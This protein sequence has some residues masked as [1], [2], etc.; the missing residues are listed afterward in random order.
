MGK[1]RGCIMGKVELSDIFRGEYLE[2][3]T[4]HISR[5]QEILDEYDVAIFMARKAICFYEALKD[6]GE[7]TNSNC[8]VVSGRIVYYNTL[9]SY[10]NKRIAVIDDVVVRGNSINRVAT[11]L[12]DYGIIADYYVAAC[13]LRFQTEFENTYSLSIEAHTTYSLNEIYH[14]SGLITQYI[15]A[16]M[17]TF[18]V[19]SPIYDVTNPSEDVNSILDDSGAVHLTSGLQEKF[20]IES[21]SIY[22]MYACTPESKTKIDEVLCNSI[23]KIRFYNNDERTIA[24]PFVLLPACDRDTLED[25][26]Q[27][28]ES[29]ELDD[30]IS[31]I[32]PRRTEE[33]KYK[34]ISYFL[35]D[36]LFYCFAKRFSLDYKRDYLND[37]LQFDKNLDD[38]NSD[39][40]NKVLRNLMLQTVNYKSSFS[41]YIFTDYISSAYQFV[42][43]RDLGEQTYE[44]A[45]GNVFGATL[46]EPEGKLGAIAFSFTD[47]YEWIDKRN[48]DNIDSFLYASSVIDVFVDMGLIVPAILHTPDN[49]ILRAYKMGEYSKLTRDQVNAFLN[50]LKTYQKIVDRDLRKIEL[51]K[52]CV[53][54]FKSLIKSGTFAEKVRFED[55]VYSI[56]YSFY[57]PRLSTS[58]ERYTV[59]KDSAFITDFVDN[60]AIQEINGRY[61]V[62]VSRPMD[63][64][65]LDMI[66]AS[67]AKVYS[68]LNK[69][70]VDHPYVKRKDD[71]EE[72]P[73]AEHWNQY[74]HTNIQFLTLLAIGNN[75]RDQILSLCAEIKMATKIDSDMFLTNT[76]KLNMNN[77]RLYLSGINSGLWKYW[78][79]KGNALEKTMT[80]IGNYDDAVELVASQTLGP[81][82]HNEAVM[83][84]LDECG[85]YLYTAAYVINE[86]L[87][88]T[89][90]LSAFRFE[91]IG[92][93]DYEE[94]DDSATTANDTEHT[95]DVSS[96]AT[97]DDNSS[98][99]K[100]PNSET[101]FGI[102][103]YYFYK[104]KKVRKDLRE[105]INSKFEKYDSETVIKSYLYIL[106]KTGRYLLDKCDLYLDT[107]NA[108]SVY[109]EEF[110]VVHSNGSNLPDS[111]GYLR[112]CHLDGITED[113]T[114]VV[115][116]IEDTK[117]LGAIVDAVI[118]ATW[119][120][121]D[122]SYLLVSQKKNQFGFVKV[123][124]KAKGT[125]I[126]DE[127]S[128]LIKAISNIPRTMKNLYLYQKGSAKPIIFD[129]Y[130]GV[131]YL[132]KSDYDKRGKL[133][134]YAIALRGENGPMGGH[135]E[136]H[137]GGGDVV[138][139]VKHVGDV[140]YGD[141]NEGEVVY[142]DKIVNNGNIKLNK[143]DK[144][145]CLELIKS[146]SNAASE[147]TDLSDKQKDQIKKI[148]NELTEETA[149]ENAKKSKIQTALTV[150][151]AITGS[152]EFVA[153]VLAIIEFF[154]NLGV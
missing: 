43:E 93:S 115:F 24:V 61:R 95:A 94:V 145:L 19:D 120:V 44:D 105:Q 102:G 117:E 138:Y 153:A 13:E 31:C 56:A 97:T 71:E 35:S 150:L 63:D 137:T 32:Y 53:L 149:K 25:L 69:V 46:N 33:N 114:T 50:M 15:E 17:R 72:D 27:L 77:Y 48:K 107:K 3:V 78:C 126:I 96:I 122:C 146:I 64:P 133:F 66:C 41:N 58:N 11:T 70:F 118:D 140:V 5:I 7:V 106:Q 37:I 76:V 55:G 51:E 16:S 121:R 104:M 82:D 2:T 73:E 28:I 135:V 52:L 148:V 4:A 45:S 141:K 92:E 116:P 143:N 134:N 87:K 112:P 54:F 12:K 109:I 154:K 74:V 113:N 6:N 100:I 34:L 136:F 40:I 147:D 62:L 110:L 38:I 21:R 30:L 125:P 85:E 20:G 49:L 22:F 129:N 91:G 89:N 8:R 123:G 59:S 131:N 139:G 84:F 29:P 108:K 18:N 57:G 14:F 144:E 83:A 39:S 68:K 10:K 80:S 132:N 42:A 98:T 99:T 65:S 1:G 60:D 101:V 47:I 67:F 26:Y 88:H 75:P 151:K 130:I 81:Y 142:G 152:A 23:I 111:Y 127:L 9:K 86:L 124:R 119:D 36:A 103:S 128:A 79:Y 90:R